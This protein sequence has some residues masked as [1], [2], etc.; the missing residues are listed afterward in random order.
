MSDSA[1]TEYGQLEVCR[2]G[3]LRE[4]VGGRI[5]RPP[6][7]LQVTP[8]QEGALLLEGEPLRDA[9]AVKAALMQML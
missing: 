8:P 9:V 5:R 1:F 4:R 2:A 3:R 6:R 7:R